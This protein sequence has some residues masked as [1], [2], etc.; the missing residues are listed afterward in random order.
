GAEHAQPHA[1]L[2]NIFAAHDLIEMWD[3]LAC[4]AKS[5][6]QHFLGMFFEAEFGAASTTIL[7]SIARNFRD[8]SGDAGLVLGFK[9]QGSGDGARLLPREYDIVFQ[10]NIDR[11]KIQGH[12]TNRAIKS[13]L[14]K[15]LHHPG[16]G[17]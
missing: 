17:N 3:A 16:R 7:K 9:V 13:L 11:E 10:P 2:R 1:G 15:P 8:S 6:Q 14:L 12:E 4:V 5:D